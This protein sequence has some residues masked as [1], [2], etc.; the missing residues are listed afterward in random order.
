MLIV[1]S[2]AKTLDFEMPH[3][4]WSQ[5][6]LSQ[7]RDQL[8]A[9]LQQHSSKKIA[10]LMKLSDRLAD[11]N[12]QRYQTWAQQP[13]QAA[14][15]AFKGDVYKGL[16]ANTWSEEDKQVAQKHLRVLSGLY[17]IL[18]PYDE[19][20][21]YRLEMKTALQTSRGKNLYQ[22]WGQQ[23]TQI[24]MQDLQQSIANTKDKPLLINLA[25]QEYFKVLQ[26]KQQNIEVITPIFQDEKNEQ[27]KVIAL[28][29]K[30]ARGLM[31]SHLIQQARFTLDS[32]K[33][34]SA[35]GYVYDEKAS[36]TNQPV[37]KRSQ[38]ARMKS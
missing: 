24:L 30:Y 38:A 20:K 1:I 16:K 31:A 6:V 37:F 29:A 2:P 23:P 32:I 9:V 7:D 22:F 5:P 17:G 36:T 3:S 14:I 25:S 8:L 13:T 34:F 35:E 33:E 12:Y 4:A 11:L 21:P 27:Y 26:L 15:H 18:K 28:Y 10:S 19:M